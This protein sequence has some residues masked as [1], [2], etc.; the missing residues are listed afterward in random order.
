MPR[1]NIVLS[2]HGSFSNFL[3]LFFAGC[4]HELCTK[5]ALYLCST[6]SCY[7]EASGPPGSVPC[8]LCRHGIVSFMRLEKA[9]R[10]KEGSTCSSLGLCSSYPQSDPTSSKENSPTSLRANENRNS[11]VLTDTL[12]AVTCTGFSNLKNFPSCICTEGL[13]GN[14]VDQCSNIDNNNNTAEVVNN[15]TAIID[16]NDNIIID[17]DDPISVDNILGG[18]EILSGIMTTPEIVEGRNME[19]IGSRGCLFSVTPWRCKL[20]MN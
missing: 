9:A 6:S 14:H 16:L 15:T 2:L 1:N 18:D 3:E 8:P 5:C 13:G 20:M 4:G 11:V 12:R 17:V 7:T 19:V 10:S